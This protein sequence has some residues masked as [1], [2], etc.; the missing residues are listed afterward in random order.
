MLF[1]V[2]EPTLTLQSHVML[3]YS[4]KDAASSKKLL[5]LKFVLFVEMYK[6]QHIKNCNIKSVMSYTSTKVPG[7]AKALSSRDL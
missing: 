7:S 2:L 5:I 3:G 6:L 1:K 4:Q